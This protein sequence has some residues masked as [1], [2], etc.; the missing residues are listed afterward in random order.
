LSVA[1]IHV[2]VLSEYVK[3]CPLA[4]SVVA[5]HWMEGTVTPCRRLSGIFGYRLEMETDD[6]E[7]SLADTPV[8]PLI[9]TSK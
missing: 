7:A 8:P 2:G 6:T 3:Y 5:F 1:K 4:T 9:T